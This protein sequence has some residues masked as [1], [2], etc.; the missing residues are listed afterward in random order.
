M[1]THI[2]N[3]SCLLVLATAACVYSQETKASKT[4]I[5]YR[6][7]RATIV[8]PTYGLS[9]VR[10]LLKKLKPGGEEELSALGEK[11]YASLSTAEKFTY[12]MIHGELSTQVCDV[13]P[14]LATEEKKIFA[15]HLSPFGGEQVWSDRQKAF[16]TQ[17]R[18]EVV[19]LLRKSMTRANRVGSNFKLAISENNY[20]ELIPDLIRVYK[21]QRKD[22]DILSVLMLLMKEAKYPPFTASATFK[23]LY[24]DDSGYLSFVVANRENQDL[25]ISRAMA[26][27]KVS[28]K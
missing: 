2:R 15:Y 19:E 14:I 8:T 5:A 22:H 17:N 27:Y 24:S 10:A 12:N 7:F 16:F 26:F 13:T 28:K 9:K 1:K 21:S 18:K 23:K 11:V 20:V 6:D 4:S 3:L 25:T